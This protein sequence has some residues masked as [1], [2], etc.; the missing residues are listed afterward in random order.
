MPRKQNGFGSSKSFSVKGVKSDKA[1]NSNLTRGLKPKAAGSYPSNRSFGST[2]S[3][4]VIERYD[5]ESDWIVWR[6]GYEYYINASYERLIQAAPVTGSPECEVGDVCYN[7]GKPIDKDPN[8][9]NYNPQYIEA[10]L[11]TQL[12]LDSPF[13]VDINFYGWRFATKNSDSNNHYVM[14]RTATLAD[15]SDIELCKV[16]E[17]MLTGPDA[18]EAKKNNE[19]WAKVVLGNDA[20]ILARSIGDR[21]TDNKTEATLTYFLN[22]KKQ[23][24]LYSG[25]NGTV[26]PGTQELEVGIESTEPSNL[27]QVSVTVPY[28][29]AI[30]TPFIQDRNNNIR[31]YINEIGLLP[32]L[33]ILQSLPSID[34]LEFI[35]DAYYFTVNFA[36]AIPSPAPLQQFFY[37]LDNNETNLPPSLYDLTELE[38][39]FETND[40]KTNIE[41]SFIFQKS[42][43]Q[44]FFGN[45]YLTAQL[46]EQDITEVSYPTMP[47]LIREVTV[48]KNNSTNPALW[49]V[50]FTAEPYLSM[51]DLYSIP[52][53]GEDGYL[54][55]AD[56]SFTETMLDTYNGEYYHPIEGPYDTVEQQIAANNKFSDLVWYR[57]VNDIDPYIGYISDT[58]VLK[59]VFNNPSVYLTL[60]KVYSC[61][62]PSYSQA[63]LRMPQTTQGAEERKINRQRNYPLPTALGKRD[64]ESI[65]LDSAAGVLESWQSDRAAASFKIC[66][67]TVAAMFDEHLKLQEPNTYQTVDAREEFGKKLSADMKEVTTEFTES[68]ER[69]G[70]TT[71]EIVFALAQGLNYNEIEI[72]DLVL[73]A[74]F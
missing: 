70:I 35:D 25:K 44:R 6:K 47:F 45:E 68:Y 46:V 15:G 32:R 61:S 51:L 65:G 22:D 28:N 20:D 14:K 26:K 42:D 40:F 62:C 36:D 64:Y 54:V 72:A 18:E 2:V 33:F 9:V 21:L 23:P 63:Q 41:G 4:T 57:K 8:S 12:Y 55:F 7:P 38:P 48:L 43:Y 5:A 56:Y 24:A 37:I 50:E 27:T 19:L 49:E 17:V 73:N 53:Q 69:G 58:G 66:K 71:L 1:I 39:V 10:E 31:A 3:R 34:T 60:A 52:D 74:K 59:P 30:S 13:E 67:H 11:N 16:T 29:E